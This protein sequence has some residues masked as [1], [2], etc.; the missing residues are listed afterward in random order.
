MVYQNKI[1]RKLYNNVIK[2]IV[3]IQRRFKKK[4]YKKQL[5][6]N[7]DFPDDING[8]ISGFI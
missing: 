5:Q 1:A 2:S 6:I 3:I 4:Y 7:S 8:I